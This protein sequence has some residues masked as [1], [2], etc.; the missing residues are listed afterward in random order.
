[1]SKDYKGKLIALEGPDG[2]GKTT[3]A[4]LLSQWLKSEDY[5]VVTTKEPTENQIGK[6]IKNSLKGDLNLSLETEALLFASDRAL[7]VSEVIR[8]SLEEGKIVITGRY[9]HSSFAYQTA[10]GLSLDWVKNINKPAIEPDLTI[11][12]DIP[13]KIGLERMNSSRKPDKFD[14]NL[15]LQKKVRNMYKQLAEKKNMPIID[16]TMPKEKVQEKI[17]NEVG[18]ILHANLS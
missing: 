3:Q 1:M 2:C 11:F 16:G 13:P 4:K 9:V 15:E 18:K 7:H 14:Q 8:P 12:I 6:I 10:R 5:E 17:R